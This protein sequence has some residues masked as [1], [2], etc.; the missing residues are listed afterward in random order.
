MP[1]FDGLGDR[2]KFY[3]KYFGSNLTY[4]MPQCPLVIRLDGR[5]FH[6]FTK[7]L[8]RPFD[9]G[10]SDL[11]DMTT[12][13]LVEESNACLGYTQSDEITLILHAEEHHSQLYLDG[14]IDKLNSLLASSASVYFNWQ[15]SSYVPGKSNTH[16]QFDCRCFSVPN[17]SEAVNALI[18]REKD[19]VRNSIQMLGQANFSHATLQGKSCDEI[20]EMLFQEKG[21][22]WNDTRSRDKRGGYFQVETVTKKLSPEE[23]EDLPPLH[24][25][26][27]NPEAVFTRKIVSYKE[28]PILTKITNQEDVVFLGKEPITEGVV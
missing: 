24:E 25:A 26:R 13:H 18:W 2:M 17:K 6:T 5:A 21:I 19:A 7:G 15:L 9:R 1:K 11:M 22:N 12:K 27:K 8:E 20:Q 28:L 14:K 10:L 23:L 3:E 16:P 4:A